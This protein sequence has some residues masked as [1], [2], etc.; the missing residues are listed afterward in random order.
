[1]KSPSLLSVK[2]LNV[3]ISNSTIL[4]K[5]SF[6]LKKNEILGVVGESG[7][8]KSITAFSIINLFSSKKLQQ[9]GEIFFNGYRIDSM[10]EKEFE[11][12]R[13]SQISMI[14][15]EPMSSLNPSMKCGNQVLETIL[16]HKILKPNK[17]LLHVLDL[18]EKV[19]LKNP[20]VVFN[21][22][23]HE[24]SGGQQQ[25]VMIA[26]AISC[27]PQI[28]IADEPTT[29]LDGIVKEEIISVLKEIQKETKMSIIFVSHDLNLISKF[30]NNIIVLNKGCIVE[31]GISNKVFNNPQNVYTKMLLSSRPPKKGRPKNLPTIENKLAKHPLVSKKDRDEKHLKIYSF[32]PILKVQNLNFAYKEKLIL[33][34]I[35]FNL[36]KG[37]TLGLVGES[38]SGK[39]TIAK[40][41]LNLNNFK[42]GKILYKN[43][44]IKKYNKKDFTKSIQLVFQDP[45]SSLNSEIRIGNSIME[46]MIAHRIYKDNDERVSKVNQLLEDVGLQMSDFNKYPRQFSG[47][48]RQRIVIARALSLNPDILIC[49]ESVSALDVSVQAQVLNLL[50]TLKER[51]SF[52]FLF[53]SHDL[54]VIKY[55]TDRVIILNKGVI[56]ELDETDKVFNNPIRDYTKQLLKANGY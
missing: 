8:G 30:A 3:T 54:S 49:D 29:S 15:Q 2:N 53:I 48:Q 40:S 56:E 24:L 11:K 34:D 9:K 38:G 41:I 37:E 14:F 43:I 28:L 31:S 1:L 21:K 47:G 12:I 4:K 51:F 33:K 32:S 45:F 6:E 44:D 55:M 27:N 42:S 20:K 35:N 13:G 5:I 7:S 23:P 36:F 26:I 25:R 19:K 22:Y 16:K 10:S 39:S 52:T 46:P 18:F 17:G 50:N